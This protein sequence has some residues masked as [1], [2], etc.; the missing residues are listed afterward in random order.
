ME[1]GYKNMEEK[2]QYLNVLKRVWSLPDETLNKI[3]WVNTPKY[4]SQEQSLGYASEYIDFM[5][6]V[7]E[8]DYPEEAW[9]DWCLIHG[10]EH[11]IE[12]NPY[13]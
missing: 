6:A 12:N 3:L 2:H 8:T 4:D 5:V 13:I 11:E 7:V 1:N 10:I 9:E